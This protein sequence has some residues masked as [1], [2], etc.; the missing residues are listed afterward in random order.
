MGES[1][2]LLLPHLRLL[3][4]RPTHRRVQQVPRP[5]IQVGE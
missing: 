4:L 1:N 2:E 3:V 5:D